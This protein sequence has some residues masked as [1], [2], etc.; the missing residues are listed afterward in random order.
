M[1]WNVKIRFYLEAALLK[2]SSKIIF[3]A[4]FFLLQMSLSV[5]ADTANESKMILSMGR[6]E[7][8][9]EEDPVAAKKEAV[10]NGLLAAVEIAV[11]ELL[12]REVLIPGFSEINAIIQGNTKHFIKRYK[13]LAE[14]EYNKEYRVV[15]ESDVMLDK[16][17]KT[18]S[19]SGIV[20]SET[21]KP[22]VLCLVTEHNL[23][24]IAP[25]YWWGNGMSYIKTVSDDTLTNTLKQKGFEI[26]GHRSLSSGDGSDGNHS[27]PG[28]EPAADIVINTGKLFGADFIITGKAI[29]NRSANSMGDSRTYTAAVDIDVIRTDTGE[30]IASAFDTAVSVNQDEIEGSREALSKASQKAAILVSPVIV[31]ALKKKA[32]SSS[33]FELVVEGD[34]F[35]FNYI[36]LSEVLGTIPEIMRLQQKEKRIDRAVLV[37]D[38]KGSSQQLAKTLLEKTFENFGITI[39]DVSRRKMHIQIMPK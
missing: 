14:V 8:T 21:E 32:E 28:P 4:C 33:M 36:K 9:D 19:A 22:R 39:S 25:Q 18:L 17:R 6:G 16:I 31:E 11:T 27:D 20:T 10:S 26:I 1:L 34:N 23:E 15:M 7:I 30:K 37:V 35:F 12:P 29:A 24:D 3:L 13:V 2:K 5:F 38:Y